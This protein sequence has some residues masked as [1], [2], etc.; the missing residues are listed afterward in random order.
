[1]AATSA[2]SVLVMDWTTIGWVLPTGTPPTT[3][4]TVGRRVLTGGEYT[5]D[6][7]RVRRRLI[8]PILE[9]LVLQ[10]DA[11]RHRSEPHPPHQVRSGVF[12]DACVHADPQLVRFEHAVPERHR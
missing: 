4:V 2:V 8:R 7:S 10:D 3:T 9:E 5:A 12:G 1:V 6:D 11:Q